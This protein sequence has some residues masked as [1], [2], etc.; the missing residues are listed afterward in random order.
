MKSASKIIVFIFFQ[1]FLFPGIVFFIT[2]LI[3]FLIFGLS[4]PFRL[5]ALGAIIML[6][7]PYFFT[8]SK[9]ANNNIWNKKT[10][11]PNNTSDT[12][13]DELVEPID[14]NRDILSNINLPSLSG[15]ND[16][17]VLQKIEEL[18]R[19][20]ESLEQSIKNNDTNSE[21]ESSELSEEE[22]KEAEEKLKF[23]E[24]LNDT[25]LDYGGSN[26]I[27]YVLP[28]MVVLFILFVIFFG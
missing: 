25:E 8:Y 10:S 7:G 6:M 13:S 9:W 3:D 17:S 23:L 11:K 16:D 19:Q 2:F 5:T 15:S 28:L 21:T 1:T 14:D 24:E 22:I 20:I 27:F 18:K 12:S 4:D 26:A